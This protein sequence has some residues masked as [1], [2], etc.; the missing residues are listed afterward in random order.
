MPQLFFFPATAGWSSLL[1]AGSRPRRRS[2]HVAAYDSTSGRMLVALGMDAGN[3]L[4]SDIWSLDLATNVWECLA[5]TDGVCKAAAASPPNGPGPRG[6][7][8]SQ[9]IGM[10][11]FV[12]GGVSFECDARGK[13]RGKSSNEL[14]A[15]N[16]AS[17]RWSLVRTPRPAS[18][19]GSTAPFQ[20]P[21]HTMSAMAAYGRQG[22]F[23][24]P[25]ALVGGADISCIAQGCIYPTPSNDIWAIDIAREELG[26][27][28]GDLTAEFDGNDIIVVQLPSWC[29][30]ASSMGVLWIDVWVFLSSYAVAGGKQIMLIDSY[31]GGNAVLRWYLEGA[32]QSDAGPNMYVV[33]VL[34]SSLD[35]SVT[36]KRWGPLNSTILEVWHHFAFTLRFARV[37]SQGSCSSPSVVLTQA[38]MFLDTAPVPDDG[39]FL[40][41]DI[42]NQLLLNT[43]I[44]SFSFGGVNPSIVSD[45][46]TY[47]SFVGSMD[48]LRIWWPSCPADNDP[49][50]CNPFGFLFPILQDGTRRPASGLADADVQLEN[51][52]L[53]LLESILLDQVQNEEGLLVN[54]DFNSQ[55][56]GGVLGNAATW[57]G[58]PLCKNPTNQYYDVCPGCPAECTFAYASQFDVNCL[59]SGLFVVLQ[60]S[61]A[62]DFYSSKGVCSCAGIDTCPTQVKNC[63]CPSGLERTCTSCQKS[64]Q[65]G[66]S[67]DAGVCTSGSK[68]SSLCWSDADC[69]SHQPMACAK[70]NPLSC[71][72]E[73]CSEWKCQCPKNGSSISLGQTPTV[74]AGSAT[75]QCDSGKTI[76]QMPIVVGPSAKY[77]CCIFSGGQICMLW[78]ESDLPGGLPTC[79]SPNMPFML[80]GNH[81]CGVDFCCLASG[82]P[83]QPS[84][85]PTGPV[86]P[87]PPSVVPSTGSSGTTCTLTGLSQGTWVGTFISSQP[88]APASGKATS[89]LRY[90]AGQKE[91]MDT[92]D[93]SFTLRDVVFHGVFVPDYAQDMFDQTKLHSNEDMSLVPHESMEGHVSTKSRH[94]GHPSFSSHTHGQQ[95]STQAR[96][97]L[98]ATQITNHDGTP[99]QR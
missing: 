88:N 10:Y 36:V 73:F 97:L 82:L 2:G 44:D 94:D 89:G 60:D 39:K 33:L 58:P 67:T 71:P 59:E 83:T 65:P 24:M 95:H 23:K 30:L 13:T 62:Q 77:P 19:S 9:Q 84:G 76:M 91:I 37:S 56:F 34:V 20:P 57:S 93:S 61:A 7:G 43:G 66:Q 46:E 98:Q 52:A 21:A 74:Q 28:D 49:S 1:A 55:S 18:G 70:L 78:K 40:T 92:E 68:V 90:A 38:Y 64:N 50:R 27:G 51:V 48:N 15:L 81:A 63:V 3:D 79:V 96:R 42:E 26:D 47:L 31:A 69:N 80:D 41:L 87:F 6:F 99:R 29:S 4:L 72:D 45:S 11:L 35:D 25:L 53:P 85:P 14:W 32:P 54:L 16:I 75:C 17:A 5:G 86:T 8:A 22:G 12:F